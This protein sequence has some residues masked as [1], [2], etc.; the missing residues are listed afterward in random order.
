MNPED[1]ELLRRLAEDTEQN[2]RML[3]DLH[4][5]MRWNQVIGFIKITLIVVPLV[6]GYVFLRPY[7]GSIA[8]TYSEVKNGL[9]GSLFGF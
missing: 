9:G 4:R 2:Y 3:R 8:E 5:Y 7:F 1:R 6:L